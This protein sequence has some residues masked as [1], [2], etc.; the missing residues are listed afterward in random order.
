MTRDADEHRADL[1]RYRFL[2]RNVRDERV[3]EIL[4]SLIKETEDRLNDLNSD[5]RS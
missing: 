3:K 1:E 5:K 2:L 4:Q